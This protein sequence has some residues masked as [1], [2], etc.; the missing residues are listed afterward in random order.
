MA[1]ASTKTLSLALHQLAAFPTWLTIRREYIYSVHMQS[2]ECT[3]ACIGIQ[4]VIE[5]QRARARFAIF[6]RGL[7]A[8]NKASASFTGAVSAKKPINSVSAVWLSQI[9]R[10]I[11]Q[12]ARFSRL[13]SREDPNSRRRRRR[14]VDDD[15]DGRGDE[16]KRIDRIG[17]SLGRARAR[18]CIRNRKLDLLLARQGTGNSCAQRL[19]ENAPV[20][21]FG[22]CAGIALY[23]EPVPE[24]A[25]H[26]SL[27]PKLNPSS[28]ISQTRLLIRGNVRDAV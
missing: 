22:R 25:I 4:D 6:S 11:A 14:D 7:S 10:C 23:S 18:V 2:A 19:H 21:G 8:E 24:A 12:R 15:D 9:A 3:C 26:A 27:S 13:P 1:K 5:I 16:V 20:C 28:P 17:R